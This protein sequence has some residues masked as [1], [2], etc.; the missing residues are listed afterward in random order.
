VSKEAYTSELEYVAW[1]VK[2]YIATNSPAEA[3]DSY[4]QIEDS[5]IANEVL[6]LIGNECY[7]IGGGM[8]L[9]SAR[10]FAEVQKTDACSD[11]DHDGLIGACVGFFRHAIQNKL[12]AGSD[13]M[14]VVDMLESSSLPKCKKIAG[15]IQMFIHNRT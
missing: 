3:W 9:Y 6:R 11:S 10:S 4:L 12:Q 14:D 5:N 2:C 8:F 7:K 13:L 1:I 15:V